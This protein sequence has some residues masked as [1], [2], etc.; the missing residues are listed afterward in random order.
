MV[1][2]W[3]SM[4]ATIPLFEILPLQPELDQTA[5]GLERVSH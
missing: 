1:N 2:V 4:A 3:S 5:D